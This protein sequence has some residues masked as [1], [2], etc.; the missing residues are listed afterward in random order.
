[1]NSKSFNG[2]NLRNARLYR[3]MTLNEL[4]SKINISKQSIS[5]YENGR[6]MPDFEKIINIS[7]VLDF[8]Y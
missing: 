3:R 8:P 1:M 6:T 2:Q 5:L 7:Y 4:A